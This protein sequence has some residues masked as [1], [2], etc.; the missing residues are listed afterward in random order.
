MSDLSYSDFES[1]LRD[2]LP[3]LDE[4]TPVDQDT[5]LVQLGLD[6]LRL[7][8]LVA[9]LEDRLSVE[10]PDDML[11][12]ETFATPTSLWSCLSDLLR[13]GS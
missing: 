6:S 4:S 9:E 13:G 2:A 1:V 8:N 10:L 3:F 5:S 12:M 7:L 11:V